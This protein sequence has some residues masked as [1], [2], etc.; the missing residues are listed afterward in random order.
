MFHSFRGLMYS[1][2]WPANSVWVFVVQMVGHFSA[3]AEATGSNPSHFS[4]QNKTNIEIISRTAKTRQEDNAKS[5][6][7][8]LFATRFVRFAQTSVKSR[9]LYLHLEMS[10]TSRIPL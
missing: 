8:L 5:I 6:K 2:N 10:S 7:T 1:I 9:V 4:S 3:N